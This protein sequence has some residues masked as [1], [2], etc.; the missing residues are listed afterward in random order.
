MRVAGVHTPKWPGEIAAQTGATNGRDSST[1]PTLSRPLV[2]AKQPKQVSQSLLR[3]WRG[4]GPE[5]HRKMRDGC[6]RIDQLAAFDAVCAVAEQ[7]GRR[8]MQ[9]SALG[10]VGTK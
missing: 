4:G 9:D 10:C 3:G 5:L 6:S 8:G 1:Y 7:S 2:L